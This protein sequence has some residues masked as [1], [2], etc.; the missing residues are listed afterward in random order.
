MKR[1]IL[2]VAFCFFAP[3]LPLLA[4]EKFIEF[5]DGEAIALLND[6]KAATPDDFTIAF[7]YQRLLCADR[8]LVRDMARGVGSKPDV[9]TAMRAAAL[10]SA[11]LEKDVINLTV[12]P[13]DGMSDRQKEFLAKNPIISYR[14]YSK[15]PALGCISLSRG[16]KEHCDPS[17]LISLSGTE[18]DLRRD[19]H[20]AKLRLEEDGVMRGKWSNGNTNNPVSMR[21]ELRLD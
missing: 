4:C 19:R 8:K 14:V 11:I 1:L 18:F 10:D 6:V 13:E 5:S 9:P 15:L 7:D 16:K 20:I 3:S 12:L 21:V 2:T 17:Y